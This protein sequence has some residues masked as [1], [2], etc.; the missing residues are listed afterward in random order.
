VTNLLRELFLQSGPFQGYAYAYPHKTAY[1]PLTPP[2]QLSTL[3]AAED[4][5]NLFLYVHLPFCEMRCAFCNLFTTTNPETNF[6]ESYLSALDRQAQVV[7][8]AVGHEASFARAAFGGGTPTL[9]SLAELERLFA[10]LHRYYPSLTTGIPTSIEASP[11]TVDE[12][13]M[14]LLKTEGCSR[15]SLGVQSFVD[16]EVR[17]LGR[18][19][20]RH[21]ARKALSIITSAN[22]TCRNVDLIYGITGQT[23]SSWQFSLEEAL[24]FAPDE[25]YLYPLY[26]RPLT[27]L[28]QKSLPAGDN[29]LALYR[30]GRDFLLSRGYQQISMR[31]FRKQSYQQPEGPVYCCQEDGM[32]GLG[33]GARSYT[34]GLHYST[35]Y[36]VGRAGVL[37]ITRHYVSR[38]HQEFA[39]ADYGCDLNLDEQKRRYVLKSILRV[40]GLALAGYVTVFGS[41]PINDFPELQQLLDNGWAVEA[42]GCLSLTSEGLELSDVIGP[43]LCSAGVRERMRT[44]TLT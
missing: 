32:L 6:I 20:T 2:R 18:A 16:D 30:A 40:P 21:Q 27:G 34:A 41:E 14:S 26:V 15:L 42:D 22:F 5:Q 17:T 8:E 44:Y 23:V 12:E 25:L 38:S 28:G 11:A 39:H 3:W 10:F 9:L 24:E 36:A 13:K 43:W 37:K 33:A 19:Q 29:R 4:K 35:E 7:A 1:R 31:L